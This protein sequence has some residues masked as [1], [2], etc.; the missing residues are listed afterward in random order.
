MV[1][2]KW[3]FGIIVFLLFFYGIIIAIN[4]IKIRKAKS[5]TFPCTYISG[6]CTV[7][8]IWKNCQ[9]MGSIPVHVCER[10]LNKK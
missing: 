3:V 4:E 2:I 5:K 6:R 10:R 1:I 8:P 7:K 9:Y